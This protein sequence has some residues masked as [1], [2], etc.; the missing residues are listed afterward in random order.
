LLLISKYVKPGSINVTGQYNHFSLLAS[1]ENLFGVSHLGYTGTPGLLVFD[2]SV[3]N[4][5]Q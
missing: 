1:I 4:A 2:T 3:Y 5:H